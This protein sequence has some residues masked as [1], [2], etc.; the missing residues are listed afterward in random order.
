M[1][2]YTA[3]I[4]HT[5]RPIFD[6]PSSCF[7]GSRLSPA[8]GGQADTNSGEKKIRHLLAP[9]PS[10]L[11]PRIASV[12][13][14]FAVTIIIISSNSNSGIVV[15]ARCIRLLLFLTSNSNRESRTHGP[16]ERKSTAARPRR[17]HNRRHR[18]M[19][20]PTCEHKHPAGCSESCSLP[21]QRNIK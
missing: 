16:P 21:K 4:A 3:Y 5:H 17:V 12:A 13:L 6:F 18:S 10:C 14:R 19:Y 15:I 20:V 8:R 2:Y 9:L 1:S 7:H 11:R